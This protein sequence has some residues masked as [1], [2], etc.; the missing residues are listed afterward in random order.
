M[1]TFTST[2]CIHFVVGYIFLVFSAC[3]QIDNNVIVPETLKTDNSKCVPSVYIALLS[4]GLIN[5]SID[6]LNVPLHGN[7]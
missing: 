3:H 4:Q 7:L 2:C 1:F 6:S 5:K